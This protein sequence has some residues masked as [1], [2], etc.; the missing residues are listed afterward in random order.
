MAYEFQIIQGMI[1][2]I[3]GVLVLIYPRLLNYIV[4][5]Y[6]I[7]SGIVLLLMRFL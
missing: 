4:G 7:L 1:S 5:L 6:F 3:F 2:I